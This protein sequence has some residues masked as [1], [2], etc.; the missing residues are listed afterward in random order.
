MNANASPFDIDGAALKPRFA[1]IHGLV[2]AEAQGLTP[3][4]MDWTSAR[5][6][7]SRWSIRRQLSH[8]AS[9]GYGWLCTRW[10][11]ELYP[12][13]LP[14]EYQALVAM[15]PDQRVEHYM[16]LDPAGLL[17]NLERSIQLA[18]DILERETPQA[19]RERHI[20]LRIEAVW[21]PMAR[22][23]P[24]GAVKDS[25]DPHRWRFSLETT[26]RHVYFELVT[27][28][29]NIQR[30]KRAQGL[31][32]VIQAPFEGYWALPDWDRSEP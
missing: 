32:A 30:L 21:D 25:G 12:G 16:R 2:A 17:R 7:W 23:H 5:W 10:G 29:Y 6:E 18:R 14:A 28:L 1:R 4:Q 11:G 13:G 27:H 31:P 19:L 22:A 3:A 20:L 8:M 26:L 15:T 24:T 9:C